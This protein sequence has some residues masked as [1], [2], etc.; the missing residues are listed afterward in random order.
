[1]ISQYSSVP[2][3]DGG[4]DL[5]EGFDCFGLARHA[6]HHVF[7]GPLLDSFAGVFR[8]RPKIMASEFEN[9]VGTFEKCQPQPGAL[10][11]CFH[12]TPGGNI[13]HHIGICINDYEVMHISSKSGYSVIPVRHFKR[14]AA[15]VEFYIYKGL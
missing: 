4:R 1:M 6:L 13:F 11:C 8:N 12:V 3:V 15:K 2:Y 9:T 10:A 5:S 7:N 14:L